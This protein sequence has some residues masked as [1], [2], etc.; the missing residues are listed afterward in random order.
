MQEFFDFLSDGFS[1]L[2]DA[3]IW[4]FF[5]KLVKT[6]LVSTPEEFAP[7]A[8]SWVV[9]DIYPWFMTIGAIMLN[10]FF[11]IGFMKSVNNLKEGVTT[12]MFIEAMIK[13]VV[14]HSL[15]IMGLDLFNDLNAISI[16]MT[17]YI[18]GTTN[19]EISSGNADV[20]VFLMKLIFGIFY[21]IIEIACSILVIVE[22]LKNRLYLYLSIC[23]FPIALSTLPG[24]RG[25]E[26]TFFAWIKA[27]LTYIFQ[28]SIIALMLTLGSLIGS[29][30]MPTLTTASSQVGG[31][32]D[33]IYTVLGQVVVMVFVTGAVKASDS[34]LEKLFGLR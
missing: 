10:L 13:V 21:V 11:Y 8:Y 28:F 20:G 17:K 30:F 31:W 23:A 7:D 4:N 27:A 24:G 22:I 16:H 2:G 9:N 5:M 34:I 19:F 14:A 6:L 15:M 3:S 26:N 1:F 12:E 18:V 33:G 32:F 29:S 25:V